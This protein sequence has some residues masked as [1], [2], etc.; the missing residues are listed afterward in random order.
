M[1]YSK[2]KE[3]DSLVRNLVRQGWVFKWG[4]KHGRIGFPSFGGKLTV[5]KTPS[6]K[7]A[8]YEFRKD[9]R[10]FLSE[11]YAQMMG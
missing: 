5:P 8:Y 2:C 9:L 7:R 3:I 4:G 10:N 1:K 6:D 11:H